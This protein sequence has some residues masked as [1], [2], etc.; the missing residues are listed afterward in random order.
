MTTRTL[1]L[2]TACALALTA[3]GKSPEPAGAPATPAAAPPEA[4]AAVTPAP[5]AAPAPVETP[6]PAAASPAP[7]SSKPAAVV[8]KCATT[9]DANDAMQYN[10][11]SITVPASCT[12]LKITL[13]HTGTM[14]VAAM[15]HDVVIA[16]ASDM[17][18][19]AADGATAGLAANYLK[20]GDAR[21]VAHSK[22]VG[23]GETT[24][25]SVPVNKIKDDGPYA[26]FCS[27]PGHVAAMNGTIAVE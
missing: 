21:V 7:V 14:P 20:P 12:A 4:P 5:A 1:L 10:V 8:T 9:I 24:S 26:F 16:K 22:L 15:G 18:A 23:G 3:C 25:V 27:F 6:A 17:Q 2:C 13:T 11:G 19:I